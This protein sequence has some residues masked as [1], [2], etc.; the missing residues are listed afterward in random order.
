MAFTVFV[1]FPQGDTGSVT[2]DA[3]SGDANMSYPLEAHDR[4]SLIEG[5]CTAI[6]VAA[7]AGATSLGS[8][9]HGMGLRDLPPMPPPVPAPH[10][11]NASAGSDGSSLDNS[12]AVESDAEREERESMETKRNEAV[13]ELVKDL[14][15]HG[16]STDYR[17][18]LFS[19]H[20][21]RMNAA[22]PSVLMLLSMSMS[23]MVTA[24]MD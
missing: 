4:E 11:H 17:T 15:A 22:H 1:S 2:I 19:A 23:Y 21:V 7:A 13:E 3:T 9:F 12:R 5:L 8:S 20:Q 14:R 16:V 18:V 24:D 6:R 10:N